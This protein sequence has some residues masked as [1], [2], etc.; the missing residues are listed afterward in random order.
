MPIAPN[1]EASVSAGDSEIAQLRKCIYDL[2]TLQALPPA[3]YRRDALYVLRGVLDA[4]VNVLKLDFVYT[5]LYYSRIELV[6][7]GGRYRGNANEEAIRQMV[8][9]WVA[10]MPKGNPGALPR[11]ISV[12]QVTLKAVPLGMHEKIG[13]L[14][15]AGQR[16]DFPNRF[17]MILLRAAANLAVTALYERQRAEDK[18]E[19]T[20]EF[21]LMVGLTAEQVASLSGELRKEMFER[22][23][24][25]ME[26]RKLAALVENSPDLILFSSVDGQVSFIN[27]AGEAMVGAAKKWAR[28]MTLLDFVAKE[29]RSRFQEVILPIVHAQGRWE[30]EIFFRHFQTSHLIPMR[31]HFFLIKE[32]QGG[33]PIGL[34][35]ISQDLTERK[36]DLHERQNAEA[37]LEKLQSELAHVTRITTMGELS[38]S[39][40]HEINQPL[41]AIVNN[42]NVCLRSLK[43]LAVPMEVREAL[44][45]IVK[46]ATRANTIVERMRALI[47]RATPEKNLLR[48]EVLISEVLALAHRELVGRGIKLQKQLSKHLRPIL[49]D[50]VQLQQV[51]L[52]LI[53]NAIEAMANVGSK[54]RILTIRVRSDTL[55]GAP[56]VRLSVEDRGPGFKAEE[57]E[58][59]FD[60]F[61]TTKSN[62]LGMGLRISRSIIEA[63]GGRLWATSD[64]RGAKFQCILLTSGKGEV[65]GRQ[66]RNGRAVRKRGEGR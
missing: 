4:L 17:D 11:P 21:E 60:A 24:A 33:E 54:R 52:N 29:E 10:A 13:I 49:G 57:A 8:G 65:S 48:V 12:G 47:K 41:G 63:H 3:W 42:G 45:D 53:V 19:L 6:R 16:R 51:L 34:A 31:Q 32:S 56:A 28:K 38:A 27:R 58:R 61:Y 15:A 5:R 37:A 66:A 26:Q 30:G 36:R 39:I 22:E 1:P 20:K 25:E 55:A 43:D 23:R 7:I 9:T 50:R 40:A 35:S 2:I 59:I 44:T 64:K 46:D 14:V 18:F 62:G